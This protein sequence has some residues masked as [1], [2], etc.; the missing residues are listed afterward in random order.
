MHDP[1]LIF[2]H[3]G[4]VFFAIAGALAAGR[5]RMDLFG[6]VVVGCVTAIGGGTLRDVLLDV[7]VFWIATPRYFLLAAA[8]AAATFFFGRWRRPAPKLMMYAD[9]GGLAL[10]TVIGFQKGFEVT[11]SYSVSVVMGVATGVAGGIMRD[12]LAGQIPLIFR[13]EI[14]ASASLCGAVLLALASRFWG[15]GV[16]S[17]SISVAATLAIRLSAIRWHL[18]LPVFALD[19]GIEG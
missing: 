15:I 12:V 14:Y 9:A 10:F 13:R 19:D 4:V 7:P 17:V 2:D 3:V 1:I 11:Q 6:V 8:A 18:S 16:L 5:K